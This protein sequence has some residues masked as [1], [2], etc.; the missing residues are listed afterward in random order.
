MKKERNT[1]IVFLPVFILISIMMP[2][3]VTMYILMMTV[4][5]NETVTTGVIIIG[6]IM[7]FIL[8]LGLWI[9]A[10]LYLLPS[11][12]ISKYGVERK[13]LWMKKK[14]SW[15]EIKDISMINTP[16]QGWLFFS[17]SKVIVSGSGFWEISKYRLK[18]DNI[19]I[20]SNDKILEIVEKY[21][22]EVLMPVHYTNI[23]FYRGNQ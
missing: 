11:V 15:E 22:P 4:G 1:F 12:K 17:E 16:T 3:S 21:A 23:T 18:K 20:A 14:L 6:T 8:P 2:I 7:L 13:L 19:F 9:W 10:F 5:R